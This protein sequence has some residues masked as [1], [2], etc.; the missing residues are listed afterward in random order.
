[1]S[2]M[3]TSKKYVNATKKILHVMMEINKVDEILKNKY[4]RNTKELAL[5]NS[6]LEDANNNFFIVIKNLK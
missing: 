5:Y 1:M 4:D 2:D 3:T 6:L